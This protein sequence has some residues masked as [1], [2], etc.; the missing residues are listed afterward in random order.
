ML[1]TFKFTI[2]DKSIVNGRYDVCEH[3]TN[4]RGKKRD[5]VLIKLEIF[6]F[7]IREKIMVNGGYVVHEHETY[8]IRKKGHAR[9]VC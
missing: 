6:N 1:E 5:C 9:A 7:M 4:K 3:V 2:R 8:I